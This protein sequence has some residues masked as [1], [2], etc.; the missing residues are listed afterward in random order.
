MRAGR[1]ILLS[2]P[3]LPRSGTVKEIC[4]VGDSVVRGGA[5]SKGGS[6]EHPSQSI[7]TVAQ[8]V[9]CTYV[10]ENDIWECLERGKSDV[11]YKRY[12]VRGMEKDF[13]Q[14]VALIY[15]YIYIYISICIWLSSV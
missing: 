9:S 11:N 8:L 15:I 2:S 1:A 4:K 14:D 6:L 3:S 10:R 7:S 12:L 5:L 13:L